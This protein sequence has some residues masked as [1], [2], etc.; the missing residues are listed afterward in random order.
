[1]VKSERGVTLI[2]LM[3]TLIIMM[4]LTGI[5]LRFTVSDQASANSVLHEVVDH[6]EGQEQ[7]ITEIE[8]QNDNAIATVEHDW[9]IGD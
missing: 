6:R 3:V 2:A 9:G 8:K 1:M 4:L 7:A 5:V